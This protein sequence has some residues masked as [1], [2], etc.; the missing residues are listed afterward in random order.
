MSF[1]IGVYKGQN[2]EIT[3]VDSNDKELGKKTTTLSEAQGR[4]RT[5]IINGNA[6]SDRD[7]KTYTG[8]DRDL[9]PDENGKIKININGRIAEQFTT[10]TNAQVLAKGDEVLMT[11]ILLLYSLTCRNLN[12]S[13]SFKQCQKQAG[14]WS[15]QFKQVYL[16]WESHRHDH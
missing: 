2:V 10:K 11:D 15:V 12:S 14:T 1:D 4:F 8:D 5:G 3:I 13:I 16:S 6:S 9:V 7:L